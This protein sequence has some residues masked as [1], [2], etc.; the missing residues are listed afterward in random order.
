[1]A[2]SVDGAMLAALAEDGTVALWDA[3]TGKERERIQLDNGP[4]TSAKGSPSLLLSADGRW[5]THPL[6]EGNGLAVWEIASG[7]ECLRGKGPRHPVDLCVGSLEEGVLAAGAAGGAV[8]VWDAFTGKEYSRV[9]GAPGSAPVLAISRDRTILASGQA[10]STA[11]LWPLKVPPKERMPPRKL[12]APEFEGLWRDLE[13]K[14]AAK[15]LQAVWGLSQA[16]EQALPLLREKVRP[17]VKPPQVERLI[18]DLD[19]RRFQVREAAERDLERLG[20]IAVPALRRTLSGQP[21]E[22]VR[23]RAQRL[24]ERLTAPNSPGRVWAA[25]VAAVLERI[26]TAGARE[27]LEELI[28][29]APDSGQAR[30]AQASLL[31]LRARKTPSE[32]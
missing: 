21:P 5:L 6:P 27:I 10:D 28:R 26:G 3:V 18:A 29:A 13:G 30:E 7:K 15:A 24:L 19:N 9:E 23:R 1:M 17:T 11:L 12:S 2:Y 16:G 14:D 25:R 22:E 4:F 20:D 8:L 31:R 32:K